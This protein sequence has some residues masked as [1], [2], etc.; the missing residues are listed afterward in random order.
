MSCE[1]PKA[2]KQKADKEQEWEEPQNT[3]DESGENIVLKNDSGESYF[4]L[5]AT[6]RCTI[7]S[8]KGKALVD[9]REFYQKD[10]KTLPGKKGISLTIE[11]FEA[12]RDAIKSGLVEKEIAAL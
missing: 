10:G 11:Q 12:L 6:K 2:K 7:R 5:S 8:F 3:E 9:I 1:E 4:E